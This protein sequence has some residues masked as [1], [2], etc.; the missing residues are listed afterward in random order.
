MPGETELKP[1]ASIWS[2]GAD[3]Y[4]SCL[5]ED[6]E[7][8]VCTGCIVP[9]D[10]FRHPKNRIAHKHTSGVD[11]LLLVKVYMLVRHHI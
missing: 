7:A 10:F 2:L 6:S 4:A 3:A 11:P 9:T 1:D 8:K 5:P